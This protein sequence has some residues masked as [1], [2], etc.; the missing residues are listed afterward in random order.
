MIR[1]LFLISCLCASILSNAGSPVLAAVISFDCPHCKVIFAQRHF[2]TQACGTGSARAVCDVRFLP[3][4]H[5]KTDIRAPIFYEIESRDKG[6]ADKFASLVYALGIDAS[7]TPEDLI[8]IL[9]GYMPGLD[10]KELIESALEN[11]IENIGKVGRLIVD[12]GIKDY[13]SFV[14]IDSNNVR[15]IP[16]P[17]EPSRRMERVVNWI[18]SNGNMLK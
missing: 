9:P 5:S 15:L 12:V 2:F 6:L 11:E 4:I 1:I 7:A 13:P 14:W 18:E 17:V 16:T 8:M 3:F 10:W